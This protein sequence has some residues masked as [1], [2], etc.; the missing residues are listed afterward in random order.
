MFS[1]AAKLSW[2]ATLLAVFMVTACAKPTHWDILSPV[3]ATTSKLRVYLQINLP[4]TAYK[5]DTKSD[6]AYEKEQISTIGNYLA[7]TGI[8]EI[9]DRKSVTAVLGD[10]KPM[11]REMERN[12]WTLAQQIGRALYADYVMIVERGDG[13]MPPAWYFKSILINV[14]TGKSFKSEYSCT[15]DRG[16]LWDMGSIVGMAI[17]DMM[18]K[19]YRDIFRSAKED[20][21]ATAF[22]KSQLLMTQ[23]VHPSSTIP[24]HATQSASPAPAMQNSKQIVTAAENNNQIQQTA[25]KLVDKTTPTPMSPS[26]DRIEDVQPV[27]EPAMASTKPAREAERDDKMVVASEQKNSSIKQVEASVQTPTVQTPQTNRSKVNDA[28]QGLLQSSVASNS[29]VIK[30]VVYDLD[31]PE[32]YRTVALIISAALREE[33]FLLKTFVLVNREDLDKVLREEALQRTG[34]IDE[35]EA[36]QAGKGLAANQIITGNLGLLGNTFVLQAKRIDVESFGVLGVTSEKFK[37]G[38]EEKLLDKLPQLARRLAG[39]Q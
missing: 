28:K 31:T 10:Q 3:P 4:V 15:I 19:A 12:D 13:G 36:V 33:L 6:K 2:Y 7:E 8:Y 21:L 35:K 22:R 9:V 26:S 1:Y 34:L 5:L 20:L 17:H 39:L 18:R 23:E 16:R 25:Q 11:L 32:Q 24:T 27:K 38:Q 14:K 37:Q 30:L 29:K